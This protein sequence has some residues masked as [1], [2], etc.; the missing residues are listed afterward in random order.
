MT[1]AVQQNLPGKSFSVLLIVNFLRADR[2][3]KQVYNK[4]VGPYYDL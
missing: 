4:M 1:L 3:I 2:K